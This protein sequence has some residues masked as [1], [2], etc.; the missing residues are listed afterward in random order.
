MA[1][2][3]RLLAL[4]ALLLALPAAALALDE[5]RVGALPPEARETLRLI[6]AGGPFPHSRDGIPFGNYER[7][8]PREKRGYYREYTVPTPGLNHRGARR[9]VAGSGADGDVRSSG[10]YWYT[11]DHYRS[12][13]RIKE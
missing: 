7:L 12:F 4:C 11:A 8:L 2:L 13:R 6:D 3:R 9:I 5:V 10:E 1:G